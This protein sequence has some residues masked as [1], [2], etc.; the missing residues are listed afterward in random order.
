MS[1]C[2]KIS[3]PFSAYRP[4][5]HTLQFLLDIIVYIVDGEAK[6][7]TIKVIKIDND[8]ENLNEFE[9]FCRKHDQFKQY[10]APCT[11]E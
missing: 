4:L 8:I 3:S 5:L 11:P 10:I 2:Y 1:Y 7:K 9:A 6:R